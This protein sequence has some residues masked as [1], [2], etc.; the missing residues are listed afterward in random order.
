MSNFF[1]PFRKDLVYPLD[2][3]N[4]ALITDIF[5]RAH[6]VRNIVQANILEPYFVQNGETPDE[7]S[8]RIYGNVKYY[9]TILLVNNIVNI[10]TEWPMSDDVLYDYAVDK[11]GENN[12][13]EPHHYI[14]HETNLIVDYDEALIASGDIEP[15]TNYEYES[16]LNS[17]KSQIN[18]LK[19]TALTDF[20][21]DFEVAIA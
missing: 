11:Y 19:A 4:R 14:D 15:V 1:K 18:L 3:V 2:K 10:Y 13:R 16:G 20:I 8:Y 21:K 12:L 7:V 9:W 17:E 5:A 6:P